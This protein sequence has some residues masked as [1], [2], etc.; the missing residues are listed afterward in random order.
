MLANLALGTVVIFLTVLIH[1]GGMILISD[2]ADHLV[3]RL[4]IRRRRA[5]MVAMV[6]LVLGL[7]VVHTAEV[8][9][10]SVTYWATG[11]LPNFNAALYFSAITFSTVGYGDIVVADQWR[12][13]AAL[14]GINGFLLIGWSTAF[15]VAAS[16]R[17]GP[18]KS[19]HHF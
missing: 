14:E 1:M 5:R 10:W 15:L 11:A 2:I 7:F 17:I 8:W 12:L 13:L 19:G 6:M 4:A 16:T 18:F 9:L 3:E